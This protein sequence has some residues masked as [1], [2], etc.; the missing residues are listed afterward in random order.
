MQERQRIDYLTHMGIPVWVPRQT[1]PNAAESSWL[2]LPE[3]SVSPDSGSAVSS[4]QGV[5]SQLD[6]ASDASAPASVSDLLNESRNTNLKEKPVTPANKKTNSSIQVKL[7]DNNAQDQ[8]T[9]QQPKAVDLTPPRFKLEFIRVSEKGVWVC[10]DQCSLEQLQRF[11]SRVMMA[12]GQAAE[13]R[14]AIASKPA[15]FHWPFIDSRHEDQSEVVALQA[16]TT[17]WQF[18]QKQG[19]EYL[20]SFGNTSQTWL[21]KVDAKSHFH[22]D[23][24]AELYS[25][26]EHK[27]KLWLSLLELGAL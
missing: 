4:I 5:D 23:D 17:Q 3:S 21:K 2:N 6:P 18:L 19:V 27:R 12:M 1:L 14:A 22:S 16:L 15:S 24:V 13:E 7:A 25:S 8:V 26:A 20:I 11:A 10:D 9:G